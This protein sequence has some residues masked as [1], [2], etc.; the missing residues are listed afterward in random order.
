MFFI[1]PAGYRR[2]FVS[3]RSIFLSRRSQQ[4][5]KV[6]KRTCKVSNEGYMHFSLC[7]TPFFSPRVLTANR[8]FQF[9]SI[10]RTAWDLQRQEKTI[11][12][13]KHWLT[14]GGSLSQNVAP[15]CAPSKNLKSSF[16]PRSTQKNLMSQGNKLNSF[17]SKLEKFP[18]GGRHWSIPFLIVK[19]N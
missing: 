12:S 10:S 2:T 3:T 19:S 6:L 7:E 13:E 16:P 18:V 15:C 5:K 8:F 9:P 17:K 14:C 11:P 4:L 1:F